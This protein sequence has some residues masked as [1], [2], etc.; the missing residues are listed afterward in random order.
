MLTQL[1]RLLSW[2]L[3]S[4]DDLERKA[5]CRFLSTE[6]PNP[7][8]VLELTCEFLQFEVVNL[9]LGLR[10]KKF[11]NRVIDLLHCVIAVPV[12]EARFEIDAGVAKTH[13]DTVKSSIKATNWILTQLTLKTKN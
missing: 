7:V 8:V 12:P 3:F 4:H 2:S 11:T 6:S 10:I 5:A 1:A 9:Q 13:G